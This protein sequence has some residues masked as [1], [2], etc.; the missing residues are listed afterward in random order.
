VRDR[1]FE[2]LVHDHTRAVTA[3]ARSLASTP[4][5]A[6]EAVAE[7]FVR[8][9]HYQDSFR[10]NGSIEGWLLRICRHCIYDLERRERRHDDLQAAL[11]ARIRPPFVEGS[12][13][14]EYD[15][16]KVVDSLAR[17]YREVI[18]LCGVLGY[19]HATA[20]QVLEVTPATL[21]SR[22]HRARRDLAR[23]LHDERKVPSPKRSSA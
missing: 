14:G 13:T 2:R 18:M 10:G 11:E 6:E 15:I 7:T 9:W 4:S 12:S 20:A 17:R 22:L 3:F 23:R 1:P 5:I 16:M 8:A 21:R 19:D